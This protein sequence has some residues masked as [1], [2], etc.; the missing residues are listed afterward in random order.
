M[1]KYS[2]AAILAFTLGLSACVFQKESVDVVQAQND[3]TVT[4]ADKAPK[5]ATAVCRDGSYSTATDNT[6]C[7]GN[8]G[9]VTQINRY[10]SE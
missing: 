8:G 7:V 5:N 3:A 2:L 1:K 4:V 6:A 10:F 9:V